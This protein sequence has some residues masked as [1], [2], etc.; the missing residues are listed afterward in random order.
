VAEA[1]KRRG[2]PKKVEGA[3]A[4]AAAPAT[5]PVAPAPAAFAALE[6]AAQ[7]ASTM[8]PVPTAPVATA[9]VVPSAP[10]V[11]ATSEQLLKPDDAFKCGVE[12][13]FVDCLPQ[14]GWPGATVHL[15]EIMHTFTRLAA[16][17]ANQP[18]YAMIR[19]ESKAYLRTA[20]KILMHAL[21]PAVVVSTAT[22]GSAEFLEV[23][24]PYTKLIVR[25]TR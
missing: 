11:S 9:P 25:G 19:Y 3:P 2:R 12:V 16:A 18:D 17:S 14:K 21:P 7:A 15:D 6:A 8:I 13:L 1:P 24:T 10:P 23:V 4:A 20:I 5:P 22:A